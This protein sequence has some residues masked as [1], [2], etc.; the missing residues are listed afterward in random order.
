[1]ICQWRISKAEPSG[2]HLWFD[3]MTEFPRLFELEPS[4]RRGVVSTTEGDDTIREITKYQQLDLL[5]E[6][7]PVEDVE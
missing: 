1:M 5:G 6:L 7:P 4:L 2:L 3:P